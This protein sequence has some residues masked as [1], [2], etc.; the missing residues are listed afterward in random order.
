MLEICDVLPID[1]CIL[2]AIDFYS[3]MKE[4]SFDIL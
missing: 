4:I 3:Y 2:N 1:L